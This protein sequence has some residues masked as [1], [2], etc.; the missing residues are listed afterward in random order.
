[1]VGPKQS[2]QI[3]P[4]ALAST[5]FLLTFAPIMCH[6]LTS[7]HSVEPGPSRKRGRPKGSK[8]NHT[9][10]GSENP[11]IRRSVSRPRGSGRKQQEAA[12]QAAERAALGLPWAQVP[13]KRLVGRPR[14][15]REDTS[16]V[17]VELR[18]SVSLVGLYFF[19]KF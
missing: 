19:C 1:M 4:L 9:P 15:E 16:S 14:K 18:Q 12:V 8:T 2:V 17:V 7:E 13:Q 3:H 6:P 5:S 10:S 11:S